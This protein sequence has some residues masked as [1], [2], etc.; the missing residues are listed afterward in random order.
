M[1]IVDL[2]PA[3]CSAL[4]V[5]FFSRYVGWFALWI[6]SFNKIASHAHTDQT[7]EVEGYASPVPS[8]L[9]RIKSLFLVNSIYLCRI[10]FVEVPS[11]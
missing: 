6:Y 10:V 9:L 7:E 1:K 3:P 5:S 4:I 2:L 11:F 8:A